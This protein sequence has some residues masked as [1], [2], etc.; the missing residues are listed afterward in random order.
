LFLIALCLV[1]CRAN[2]DNAGL[3]YE[4]PEDVQIILAGASGPSQASLW[5]DGVHHNYGNSI[6]RGLFADQD[7]I[8]VVGASG[9]LNRGTLWRNHVAERVPGSGVQVID[10]W[11]ENTI[12]YMV[13]TSTFLDLT[14]YWMGDQHITLMDNAKATTMFAENGQIY[15]GGTVGAVT[16]AGYWI[17]GEWK[18]LQQQEALIADLFVEDGIVYIAGAYGMAG[19]AG[20]WIDEELIPIEDPTAELTHIFVEDGIIYLAGI[21]GPQSIAAYWVDGQR[22]DLPEDTA[23]ITDLFVKDGTVYLSGSY[24]IT[25]QAAFWIDGQRTDLANSN[26]DVHHIFVIDA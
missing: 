3:A 7:T 26:S 14:T 23:L 22:F 19:L 25:G 10:L 2:K 21:S 18:P 12:P 8:Y 9:I 4:S 24:G 6:L 17:N 1:G 20:I 13:G 15:L 16:T 5:V 11:V